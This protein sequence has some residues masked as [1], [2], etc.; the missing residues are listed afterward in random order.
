MPSLCILHETHMVH[1]LQDISTLVGAVAD[2]VVTK[3][4]AAG[5][6]ALMREGVVTE[7]VNSFLASKE[8]Y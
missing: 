6:V 4:D 3:S 2:N 7:F 8:E 5:L 1:R